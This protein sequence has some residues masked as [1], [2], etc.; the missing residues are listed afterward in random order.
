M[1]QNDESGSATW[2]FS[3]VISF[4]AVTKE[5]LEWMNEDANGLTCALFTW[6][7]YDKPA[8]DNA[9]NWVPDWVAAAM[10]EAVG[11]PD[12]HSAE[13]ESVVA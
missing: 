3:H 9:G 11:L 8:K 1:D 5:Q 4:D 10:S 7:W 2:D 12:A 13:E 6:Q